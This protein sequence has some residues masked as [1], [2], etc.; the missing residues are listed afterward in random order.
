MHTE[1]SNLQEVRR[2]KAEGKRTEELKLHEV[3]REREED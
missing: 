1:E 3:R 2:E